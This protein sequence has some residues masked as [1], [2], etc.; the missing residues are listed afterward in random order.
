VR[1]QVELAQE[2]DPVEVHVL[3]ADP[4]VHEA[5]D[6]GVVEADGLAGG[7]DVTG[8]GRERA[9]VCSA[10]TNLDSDPVAGLDGGVNNVA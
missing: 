4:S 7:R 3:A 8:R 1:C 9:A 6:V 5:D 2:G 10:E